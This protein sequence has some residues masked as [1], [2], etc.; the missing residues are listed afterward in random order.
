MV[1]Q[2]VLTPKR[3]FR[4]PVEA[5]KVS[6]DVF[7]GLSLDDIRKLK[8]YEGNRECELGDLFEV[9]EEGSGEEVTIVLEG[10]LS[11]DSRVGE[12]MSTGEI[13]VN[14]DIGSF[15][16]YKMR[17]SK[18][19]VKGNAGSWLGAQM[20]GGTIEVFG[21]AG[22]HIGAALRGLRRGKGMSKG[23]IIVHGNAG[24]EVGA[25]MVKGTIIIEGSC[26]VFP[27]YGMMG[28]TILIKGDCAGK[29][30]AHMSGGRIVVCGYLPEVLPSFYID[31]V[32]PTVKVKKMKLEGPFYLFLGDALEDPKC[33]GRLFV[34]AGK[35]PHL[36]E[37]GKLV[38]EVK[39]VD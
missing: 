31:S 35:N 37:F 2:V 30:G 9:R 17:G 28:G 26:A 8:V 19:T 34:H 3:A 18:I 21:N 7:A 12:G 33:G 5:E 16:G 20:A 36:G 23:M 39:E 13:V 1:R 32:V 4:V 25:G 11:K 15:A 22:D 27:G 38:E 29:A 6:P 14:G 24:A 10:N